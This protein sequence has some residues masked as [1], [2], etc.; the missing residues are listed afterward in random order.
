MFDIPGKRVTVGWRG[1]WVE[2][3]ELIFTL[4]LPSAV[5]RRLLPFTVSSLCVKLDAPVNAQ[6]AMHA[7]TVAA[8]ITKGKKNHF[9]RNRQYL[10]DHM[11]VSRLTTSG[12]KRVHGRGFG[13]Y[14]LR[15]Q[16]LRVRTLHPLNGPFFK[17]MPKITVGAR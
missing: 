2:T 9:Q 4:L 8:I 3:V 5:W 15:R 13:I 7:Y 11:N 1:A 17:K 14:S 10:S 16:A 6:M 12:C